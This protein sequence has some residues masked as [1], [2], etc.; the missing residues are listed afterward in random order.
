MHYYVS[1]QT[2]SLIALD[3]SMHQSCLYGSLICFI[4]TL[5]KMLVLTLYPD[6]GG[7]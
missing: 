3:P 1:Y 7:T 6:E 4:K 5:S 2:L